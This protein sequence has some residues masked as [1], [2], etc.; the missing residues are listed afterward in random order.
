MSVLWTILLILALLFVLLLSVFLFMKITLVISMKK[1]RGEKAQ[2][3]VSV[4]IYGGKSVFNKTFGKKDEKKDEKSSDEDTSFKETLSNTY[5]T[6]KG[7]KEVYKLQRKK[8]G[9]DVSIEKIFIKASFGT[10]DAYKT[11]MTFGSVQ[12]ALYAVIA[13][14]SL[15]ATVTEPDISIVPDFNEEYIEAEGEIKIKIRVIKLIGMLM[16]FSSANE[17]AKK[18]SVPKKSAKCG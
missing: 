8:G 4:L 1:P 12:T 9:K 14:F 16:A 5:T 11:A 3:P 10:D 13:F 6:F 18:C 17:K 7:I 15:I 2:F